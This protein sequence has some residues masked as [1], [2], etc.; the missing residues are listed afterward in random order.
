MAPRFRLFI[1]SARGA[2]LT[3]CPQVYAEVCARIEVCA[4]HDYSWDDSI[5][6]PERNQ[7]DCRVSRIL[8]F[9]IVRSREEGTGPFPPIQV[10]KSRKLKINTQ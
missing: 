4:H 9:L 6:G 2:D 1:K 3:T 10:T 5:T 7:G 8:H